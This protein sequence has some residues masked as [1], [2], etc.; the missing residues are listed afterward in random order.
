MYK[1]IKKKFDDNGNCIYTEYS[2]GYW[3]K[4]E[5]DNNGDVI[6]AEWSDGYWYKQEFDSNNNKIYYGNSYGNQIHYI[7]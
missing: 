4:Y 3:Y 7:I 5:Y 6:Y 1:I 2:D